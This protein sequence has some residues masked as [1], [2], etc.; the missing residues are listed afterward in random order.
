MVT[1][2]YLP[3]PIMSAPSVLLHEKGE[4]E[5]IE[6]LESQQDITRYGSDQ[7]T[8]EAYSTILAWSEEEFETQSKRLV[9][10]LDLTVGLPIVG[11]Y[12]LQ[13]ALR[14]L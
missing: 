6:G 5:F 9:R 12:R 4:T 8:K 7:A 3:Q 2:A 14:S 1:S 10:R 11:Q 13:S